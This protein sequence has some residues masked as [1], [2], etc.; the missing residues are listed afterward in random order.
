MIKRIVKMTFIPEKIDEFL[1]VFNASKNKIKSFEGCSHLELWKENASK[2]IF[3]TYSFWA[4]AEALENYR[5]SETFKNIWSK[6]KPLFAEKA[7]AWSV[8]IVE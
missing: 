7:E 1:S 5:N 8:E 3:F 6:T 2:N 4:S